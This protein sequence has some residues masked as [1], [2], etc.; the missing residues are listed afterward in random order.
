MGEFKQQPLLL[1]FHIS[2][3]KVIF[4]LPALIKLIKYFCVKGAA[5]IESLFLSST[6]ATSKACHYINVCFIITPRFFML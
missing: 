1:I 6:L 4:S 3:M 5:I 2:E